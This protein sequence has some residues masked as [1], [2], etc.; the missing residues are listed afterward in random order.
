[1][2][3][4]SL[5]HHAVVLRFVFVRDAAEKTPLAVRTRNQKN[6]AGGFEDVDAHVGLMVVRY[7][8]SHVYGAVVTSAA[9]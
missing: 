5:S 6:R 1:M 7:G 4:M 3:D 9:A 8:V 2:Q